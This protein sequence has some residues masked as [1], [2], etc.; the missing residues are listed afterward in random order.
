MADIIRYRGYQYFEAERGIEGI[1]LAKKVIPDLIIIDLRLPDMEGYEVTTLLKSIDE[2]KDKPIIALTA[3]SKKNVKELTLAAGCDGFIHKPINVNEFLFKIEEYLSGRRDRL[4]ENQ[5]QQFLQ[6][7]N[8]ELVQK[9]S[10][11]IIQ[12]ETINEDL[13][14]VNKELSKS[15]DELGRYNDRLFYLN[16]LANFLRKR[17]NP[18]EVLKILPQKTIEGFKVKRCIIFKVEVASNQLIPIYYAGIELKRFKYKKF[19]LNTRLFETIRQKGG[20]VWI[21]NTADIMEYELEKFSKSLK[22]SSFILSKLND[23]GARADSTQVLKSVTDLDQQKELPDKYILFIDK[24]T[25]GSPV[26]TYEVRILKSFIQ[27][28]GTIYENMLLYHHLLETYKI[29][30]QQ[31][32][33]DE[34]TK[35]YNYRYL[36]RELEREVNRAQRFKM[37]FSIIMIDIDHFKNYNDING[38]QMG[39]ALLKK[40]SK[41]LKEN[42]RKTDTIA[43]YGGEEFLIVLP[44]VKKNRGIE[45]ADK[46]QS[47]V[48][49]KVFPNQKKQ[50]LG[51]LTI[52]SGLVSFPEDGETTKALLKNVDKALYKAKNKGR[53]RLI[54]F[55]K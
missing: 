16:N 49:Q 29:R 41:L 19:Q 33:T 12:L 22:T 17:Q 10:K 1:R 43:R 11:K 50:P 14:N 27:T 51:N 35:V 20:L 47:K 2:L 26:E 40:F 53:N 38:H 8:V 42:T 21:R 46:L 9:L 31:A 3:E 23:L 36:M 7:Y 28:V 55:G 39:D 13:Y 24:G 45:I 25:D 5:Q 54:V 30:E 32:V 6:K 37:P 34:L 4:A 44:G 52:S 48:E 15:K 18:E